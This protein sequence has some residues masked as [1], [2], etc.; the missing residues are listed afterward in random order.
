MP[1]M[2]KSVLD[3]CELETRGKNSK[4]WNQKGEGRS[5][6]D[7]ILNNPF[8]YGCRRGVTYIAQPLRSMWHFDRSTVNL[9]K[10]FDSLV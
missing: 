10:G 4:G 6:V 8:Q 3:Q 1:H 2:S 7:L 9:A 5:E